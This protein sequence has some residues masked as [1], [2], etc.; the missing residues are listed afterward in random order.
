M[1][2][3]NSCLELRFDYWIVTVQNLR[4]NLIGTV[5]GVFNGTRDEF[6]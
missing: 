4:N 1:I 5:A 2:P 6:C 3:F